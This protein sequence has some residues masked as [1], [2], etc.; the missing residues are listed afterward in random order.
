MFLMYWVGYTSWEAHNEEQWV[1]GQS[2]ELMQAAGLSPTPLPQSPCARPIR[3]CVNFLF[4]EK[5]FISIEKQ[6]C[7]DLK[8]LLVLVLSCRR[9]NSTSAEDAAD[10]A[11]SHGNIQEQFQNSGNSS[12][13]VLL[14]CAPGRTSFTN[15][16]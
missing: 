5:F 1:E 6:N 15:A 10:Q 11:W 8:V 13:F 14:R 12:S 7:L 9:W 4:V 3:H 16:Q 2:L